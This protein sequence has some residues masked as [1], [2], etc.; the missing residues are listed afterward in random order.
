VGRWTPTDHV[1]THG[2]S[3]GAPDDLDQP[4][5]LGGPAAAAPVTAAAIR[6]TFEECGVLLAAPASPGRASEDD[7]GGL[8]LAVSSHRVGI[9]E[10]LSSLGL[11]PDLSGLHYVDRWITPVGLPR[12]YDTRFIATALPQGSRPRNL[13]T[14]SDTSFWI[15]PT[16]ALDAYA[17]GDLDLM[18]PTWA[19]L[20]R[21][22]TAR[23][24][25]QA[26]RPA[27]TGVTRN[28]LREVDGVVIPWGPG[29]E[30]YRAS[31]P[32]GRRGGCS[33]ASGAVPSVR[34]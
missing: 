7:Q 2:W 15:R 32:Q 25:A 20:R 14:E 27:S 22:A 28:V 10:A 13:S 34:E 31:G 6:E 29:T 3:R 1:D 19:Q 24:V 8:R 26:L 5:H 12:R 9:A 17:T 30:D 21:L 33:T 23:T 4:M 16:E 11:T 18:Q